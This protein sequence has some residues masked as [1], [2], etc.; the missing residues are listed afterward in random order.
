MDA[1]IKTS[2]VPLSRR[3]FLAMR[4]APALLA[5]AWP[6]GA[7]ALPGGRVPQVGIIF[8]S[9]PRKDLEGSPPANKSARAFA[10]GLRDRGWVDGRNIAIHWRSAEDR[11]ERRPGLIDE[12]VRL[13]VDV[14][15][16][17]GN[18]AVEEA[19]R[20]TRHTPVVTVSMTIDLANKSFASLARPGGNVTG[21]AI[22]TGADLYGKRIALLK[23]VSPRLSRVAV[24]AAWYH[25]PEINVAGLDE[26]A[27]SMGVSIFL[28]KFETV[29]RI[30]AAVDDAVRRGANGFLI[31]DNQPFYSRENVVRA[32]RALERHRVPA[33]HLFQGSSDHGALMTHSDDIRAR[34]AGAAGYVDK[35]LRGA[36][37][38]DIPIEQPSRFKLVINLR[39]AK[40]IGVTIPPSVLAQA[41]RFVE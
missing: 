28:Q 17:A 36:K 9:A 40:A 21:Y 34:Y 12:L 22:D 32:T 20:R 38:G 24:L 35:I 19:L 2:D 31:L 25:P 23:E 39:A 15:V 1:Q 18:F 26:L 14:L 27:R 4:V 30:G 11:Y 6:L 33:I 16:V 7:R 8:N 29:D 13:P 5:L 37:P 41:D 3:R 10:Q